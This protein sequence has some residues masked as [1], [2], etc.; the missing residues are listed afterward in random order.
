MKFN[1]AMMDGNDSNESSESNTDSSWVHLQN[2]VS[3]ILLRA[4]PHAGVSVSRRLVSVHVDNSFHASRVKVL[5]SL[6]TVAFL[7]GMSPSVTVSSAF[8]FTRSL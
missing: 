1:D 2:A 6:L 7:V 5:C 4:S 3:C 8:T